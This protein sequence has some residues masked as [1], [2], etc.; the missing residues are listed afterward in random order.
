MLE[1]QR[2]LTAVPWLCTE[3]PGLGPDRYVHVEVDPEAAYPL[4]R[5]LLDWT[6]AIADRSVRLCGDPELVQS[7]PTWFLPA[8]VQ[9][10]GRPA[11]P[12]ADEV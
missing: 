12:V 11:A 2:R 6:A 9:T 4:S 5:G 7:V 10:N 8:D 1:M 3:D